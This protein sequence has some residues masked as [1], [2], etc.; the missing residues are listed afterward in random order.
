MKTLINFLK[1]NRSLIISLSV[2]VVI[3]KLILF[4]IAFISYYYTYRMVRF[5]ASQLLNAWSHWDA[6][7]YLSIVKSGYNLASS[8][9]AFFPLYPLLVKIFSFIFGIKLAAYL[10]NTF[11]LFGTLVGLYKLV[12]I[13]LDDQTAWRAIYY[14]LLF[15]TAVFLTA[16]YGEITFL[17]FAVWTFYF[18][19]KQNWRTAAFFGFFAGLAR[20][21]AT[22]LLIFMVYEYLYSV[23]FNLKNIKLVS[24]YCLSPFL[25]ISAYAV[26]LQLKFGDF[27]L[28]L[29]SH[30]AWDRTLTLP[31]DTI[32]D[33]IYTFFQFNIA[34]SHY[35]L[36]RSFDLG[37]LIAL[38][39]IGCY[40]ILKFRISYGL[41]VIFISLMTTLTSTL[42]STTRK[43]LVT[44]P[45]II[46]L[47]KHGKN[48]VFNFAVLMLFASLFALFIFRYVNN[49]WVG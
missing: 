38:L 23:K 49:M 22:A 7:W 48:Q 29:K 25:G 34:T 17:F 3:Y 19:R 28:F 18:T 11:A 9:T 30:S 45:V 33:Y 39:T 37:F 32:G 24:L 13:D 40:M 36:A 21:E 46:L 47:A 43:A 35:Y 1:A 2:L 44:F 16:Y 4:F 8:N 31:W 26:Y 5:D 6:G 15:P 14:F 10:V 42:S 12:K 27:L 20:I 41:F